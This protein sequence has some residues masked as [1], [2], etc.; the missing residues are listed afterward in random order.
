L[1]MLFNFLI[2]ISEHPPRA[3]TSAIIDINLK[4]EDRQEAGVSVEVSREWAR[5][6]MHYATS[7]HTSLVV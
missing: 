5:F 1:F 6:A 3:D 2:R 7:T 4:E